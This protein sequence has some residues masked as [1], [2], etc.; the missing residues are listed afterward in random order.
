MN[1]AELS[2]RNHVVAWVFGI[3]MLVLGLWSYWHL[4]RLEDPEFTIKDA[5]IITPYPGASAAEVEEEVSNVIEMAAQ[6]MEQLERVVSRSERGRST[7]TVTIRDQYGAA[8][9][10][11]VWDELRRR[12][13]DAQRFLPPGAGPSLVVDDFG[14]VF[15]IFFALTGSDFSDADLYRVAKMLRRELLLVPDVKKVEL[16]G[17]QQEVVYVEM[18]RD[19][20]AS[21][22]IAPAEVFAALQEQ[23]LVVP[24][25][26]V[27]AGTMSFAI[28]PSGEWTSTTEFEKLL[29]RGGDT[30]T[31]IFLGDIASVRR[32]FIDPPTTRLRYNGESAVGIGIS[33]VS[34]GNVVTMGAAIQARIAGLEG[35]IPL[36][37]EIHKISFQADTVTVAIRDFV[38]NLVA[39]VV[40]VFVVLLL[41]MGLRSGLIIGVILAI[42]MCGTMIFMDMSGIILERISLGALII[43]LGMLVDNAIVITEGMLIAIQRG[44]DRLQA[45]KDI[46]SQTA[47]PLLGSTAI[48]ILAFG[49]IGLSDDRTGEY[50]RSLFVVLLIALGLSWVT[51]V[52]ITPL[53]G[54]LFLKTKP[55]KEGESASNTDPYNKGVY[56]AYRK[57]LLVCL[58]HRGVSLAVI[59]LIFAGSVFGFRFVE[60]NFFPDSTR[61]QFMLNVWLPV[62]TQLAETDAVTLSMREELASLPGVT[63]ITTS[64]G[65]GTLRF[66]L[67]YSPERFDTAYAQFLIDVENHTLIENLIP[68]AEAMLEASFPEAMV[69]GRRFLLGPG[70]GGRIQIRFS[71]EDQDELRKLAMKSIRVLQED[72]GAKGIRLDCREQVPVLR[73]QFSEA[74]ARLVGITRTDLGATLEGTFSGRRIGVYREG[75]DLLP[76][77]VRSPEEERRDPDSIQDVQIF[78]P[79][80][81]RFIP[82][83][84]IV[85]GFSMEMEDP[86]IMRRNR[87]PTVT[88]H[89]E[90]AYGLASKL[91]E[92]IAPA[93]EA[94]PLPSGY[95]MEWGGEFEDS[96]RA[97]AALAAALPAFVLVMILIVLMLFNSLRITLMIWLVVPLALLGIVIGLLVFD[98]PFGFMAMLGAL[99]LA[100]MLIKNS[101][102]LV[103]EILNLQRQG[104]TAWQAVVD[105][106]V[107]RVRPVSMAAL[108][109]V[110]GLLPLVPDVFFGAMAVT[111]VVGLLFATVLTLFVIPVFYVTFFRVYPGKNN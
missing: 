11:Q 49:A 14:D 71:G 39:A 64:V 52:T 53:F 79:A 108:T 34:G 6:Q 75:E 28:T 25:G 57:L 13:G 90:Q 36:G 68:Q 83:R 101:I 82:V 27:D 73:P 65:Q 76:V 97:Q 35:V 43:S 70:E 51:A 60:N 22:G 55:P 95:R 99:S 41:A 105:A 15:G 61:E 56:R 84:Q 69:V 16:F 9:L 100:G 38:S 62:G 33:T 63:H 77:I 26:R 98:Q 109:T 58:G 32:D 92:R 85:S 87:S 29:I 30:G 18:Q 66:L 89:A 106:A 8:E 5:L 93:I 103:D 21:L 44:K 80:A 17:V 67:T 54:F 48:A 72:G 110:L 111:I 45:A 1:P 102:V 78:S 88:V 3:L 96:S 12:V 107:S 2:I 4:P 7:V 46:V 59:G 19:Q 47:L 10:P 31:L 20:M 50:T 81:N 24:A 42:T 40:I 94:I 37:M 104:I 86:I 91:R 74:Q 23:N